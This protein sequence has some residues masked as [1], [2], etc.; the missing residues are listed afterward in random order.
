VSTTRFDAADPYQPLTV[1][2]RE[3]R[4]H[5]RHGGHDGTQGQC[6][7]SDAEVVLLAVANVVKAALLD[8]GR[9]GGIVQLT[10][11]IGDEDLKVLSCRIPQN[12]EVL[13]AAPSE[14]L[15]MFDTV[16]TQDVPQRIKDLNSYVLIEQNA[17][18]A[19]DARP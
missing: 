18:Q 5:E 2:H 1:R 13:L 9:F 12:E 17:H 4:Y 14:L 11:I 15:D 7:P 8:R 19:A 16:L 3:V 6:Q 10:S